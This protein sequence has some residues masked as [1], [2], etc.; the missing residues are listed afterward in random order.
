VNRRLPKGF[1]NISKIERGRRTITRKANKNQELHNVQESER[2]SSDAIDDFQRDH[3]S[4][5]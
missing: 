3:E 4:S 1:A 2:N 5:L